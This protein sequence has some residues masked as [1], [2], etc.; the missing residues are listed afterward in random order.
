MPCQCGNKTIKNFFGDTCVLG[1]LENFLRSPELT[2]TADAPPSFSGSESKS[3]ENQWLSG[4]VRKV[5]K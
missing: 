3:D 4:P 1:D 2:E 5:F